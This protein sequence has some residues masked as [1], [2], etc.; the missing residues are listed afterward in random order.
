MNSRNLKLNYFCSD[1]DSYLD[2]KL[3]SKEYQSAKTK[4]MGKGG[5]FEGWILSGAEWQRF[6]ING[7]VLP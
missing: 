4:L 1:H 2:L 5:P 7:E 6:N 3:L